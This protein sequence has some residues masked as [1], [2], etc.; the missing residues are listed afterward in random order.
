MVCALLC[1]CKRHTRKDDSDEQ[2][3]GSEVPA[4]A[5][6]RPDEVPAV[7]V[8]AVFQSED[9]PLPRSV[10][11][12]LDVQVV[13]AIME[14][15][16]NLAR[17]SHFPGVCEAATLVS[18]LVN[19]ISHD[20]G[21]VAETESRLKRCSLLLSTLQRA[22]TVLGKVRQLDCHPPHC[23]MFPNNVDRVSD[24]RV[25]TEERSGSETQGHRSGSEP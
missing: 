24:V 15:A 18:T 11:G 13:D 21:S 22:A 10:S 19:L 7:D 1:M 20:R 16:S 2:G 8:Q 9:D 25:V 3:Q 17:Q 6:A 23:F 5:A 4:T 14:M 12:R